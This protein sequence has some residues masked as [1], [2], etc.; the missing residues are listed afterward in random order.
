[1]YRALTLAFVAL[2]S[3]QC[4]GGK[5]KAVATEVLIDW[6]DASVSSLAVPASQHASAEPS[7]AGMPMPDAM[8]APEE[9]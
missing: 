5:A 2:L 8:L 4:G 1:M 9:E 3:A 6:P 7:D